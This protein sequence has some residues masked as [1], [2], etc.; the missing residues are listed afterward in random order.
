MPMMVRTP[1]PFMLLSRM[2]PPMH[3]L[4]TTVVSV[5][6]QPVVPKMDTDSGMRTLRLGASLRD[7]ATLPSPLRGLGPS[8]G[9]PSRLRSLR[10]LRA[11]LARRLAALPAVAGPHARRF[12]RPNRLANP[13][14]LLATALR[15]TLVA[16]ALRAPPVSASPFT[17]SR[18]ASCTGARTSADTAVDA[19]AAVLRTTPCSSRCTPRRSIAAAAPTS[20]CRRPRFPEL[21]CCSIGCPVPPGR[22]WVSHPTH[23]RCRCCRGCPWP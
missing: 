13:P 8:G 19:S 7:R 3:P 23:L 20:R 16:A 12:V 6:V 4:M 22:P 14:V 2:L 10:S 1:V 21:R 5:V 17:G 9:Y 11:P 18:T 15:A